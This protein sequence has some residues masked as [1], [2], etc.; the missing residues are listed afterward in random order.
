MKG[1][2]VILAE[3]GKPVKIRVGA[4]GPLHF[5]KG[6]YAYVGSGMGSLGKRME[7]HLSLKKKKH[8]H[9]DYFLEKAKV[10]GIHYVES[11]ERRECETARRMAGKFEGIRNFGCSDCRCASHL[12]YSGKG[13]ELEREV[14]RNLRD[15][16]SPRRILKPPGS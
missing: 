2:Y 10:L 5:R 13:E 16:R 11:G 8:W 3:L 4:L 15:S 12:F 6:F 7:R 1:T 14:V 9:I